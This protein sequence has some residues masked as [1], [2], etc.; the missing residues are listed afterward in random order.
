MLPGGTLLLEFSITHVFECVNP[1]IRESV[2]CGFA[3]S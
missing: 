1:R 3:G 2:G